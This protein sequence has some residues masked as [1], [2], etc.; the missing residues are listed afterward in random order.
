[1]SRRRRSRTTRSATPTKKTSTTRRKAPSGPRGKR[2]STELSSPI[3]YVGLGSNVGNRRAHLQAAL[4][5]L[6]RRAAIIRVSPLY[7][8]APVG[9]ARQRDFWNAV[10]KLRWK[11]SAVSLL[12]KL[13][14]IERSVGRTP[15][16]RNGP[17]EIDLDLL[18]FGGE[19]RRR[20]AP[21][22]PHPRMTER[23]F[24]LAP[25]AEVA[26]GWRHPVTGETAPQ[27]LAGLSR[28]PRVRRLAARSLTATRPRGPGGRPAGS[29]PPRRSGRG[30]ASP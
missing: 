27:L 26:P 9:F 3:A 23:R 8:T 24:V 1:M 4:S 12:K 17:R 16:F 11:G 21:R 2:K 7:C 18:D 15:T 28:A 10:V 13:A 20:G 6:A 19:V 14:A 30:T 29:S 25:L 22:L 5:E